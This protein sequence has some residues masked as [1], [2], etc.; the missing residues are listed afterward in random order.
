[1]G[2]EFK[3]SLYADDLLIYITDPLVCA[4]VI[5]NILNNFS[6][7]SGYKI[8]YSKSICFPIN[9]KASIIPEADLPFCFSKTGFKYL[10]INV[11]ASFS[12]LFGANFSPIFEKMKLDL[13]RWNSLCLSLAGRVN[14]IKMN[15]LPRF[16]YLF[17]NLPIFL[18]KSFF[19]SINER[20]SNFLWEGKVPRLRRAFLERPRVEGG[21][22]LPN[23][24]HYYWAANFQKLTYWFQAPKTDW[25][26][27]EG[28]SCKRSSL[29]ALITSKLPL[30]PTHFSCS[31]VVVSTLRIW[32]Q[33]RQTFKLT[34]MS[35]YSPI[36]NNHLFPPAETDGSF[37]QW[38][39][40][41]LLTCKDLF[42]DKVFPTFT[43]FSN[44]FSISKSNFFRY[45]QIR[46]FVKTLVPSFPQIP[47]RSVIEDI[48]QR[49]VNW[50]GHISSIYTLIMSSESPTTNDIKTKWQEELGIDI[51]EIV[52]DRAQ[53]WVNGTSPCARLNLIQFKVFHRMHFSKAKLA[54]IYSTLDDTCDRCKITRGD[55]THMFWACP[56]LTEYWTSIF[57]ILNEVFGLHLQ[58]NPATAIFGVEGADVIMPCRKE[59]VIAFATLIARRRILLEWKSVTPPKV[60][61]W[62]SD[63][64][65]FLKLEKIKCFLKGHSSKK[66]YKTWDPLLTY[67]D[68][69]KTLPS[70]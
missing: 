29:L 5:L 47:E 26:A 44:K 32:I 34:E 25:C 8:N 1:M 40:N 15:I 67:F 65:M 11:T 9:K 61:V 50:R 69:L 39:H 59:N 36:C 30:S 58:P 66:F 62:L 10:G 18:P 55:L 52:W 13:Q 70:E 35:I 22:A 6:S 57:E 14:C 28:K 20:L 19:R 17:Q 60:S 42:I 37:R 51:S 46:H 23:F 63:L 54:K 27:A 33:F 68:R 31:P 41:G 12:D 38:R 53:S 64:M 3:V 48:L 43:D 4:P 49:P 16:L 24:M 45:L 2:M 21:L 56:K 7:F